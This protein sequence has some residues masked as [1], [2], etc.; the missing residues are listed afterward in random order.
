MNFKQVIQAAFYGD[1]WNIG[2]TKQSV[3]ELLKQRRLNPI[4]W[5]KEQEKGFA[6]DP[7]VIVFGD[8]VHIYYEFMNP[9]FGRGKIRLMSDL[10][11]ITSVTVKGISPSNIHLS[12][13]YLFTEGDHVYC[14]P[15]TAEA[16]EVSLFIVQAGQM[17]QMEKQRVLLTGAPFVDSS[18]VKY[19]NKY[20]L[21]TSIKDHQGQF[22]IFYANSLYSDFVP[23][24]S[25]PVYCDPKFERGAGEL[26]I[27]DG[28]LYRPTQN[29]AL[30]YGGSVVISKISA[31]TEKVF[32]S[33]FIM[34]LLPAAPY[35]D[36]LHH[37]SFSSGLIVIDGKR[38][39]HS[40]LMLIKKLLREF[41]TFQ[42]K[43]SLRSKQNGTRTA[44]H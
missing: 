36:G 4:K 28:E 29:P 8:I 31:L 23:H 41:R 27:H 42:A 32:E 13:P 10:E 37:I 12:Y 3:G 17:A 40:P 15:E 6:A 35:P 7:F 25:S 34:E 11:G 19:K 22:S 2:Y 9:W 38:R 24:E 20:W 44:K 16:N 43:R 21:F 5:L 18:L 30:G 14:I 39:I 26:F 1:Q 33:E